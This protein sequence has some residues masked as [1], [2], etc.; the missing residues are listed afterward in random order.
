MKKPEKP[1]SEWN[2]LF[3]PVDKK[4]SKLSTGVTKKIAPIRLTSR[5]NLKWCERVNLLW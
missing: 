2:T 3:A 1:K 5:R 4:R